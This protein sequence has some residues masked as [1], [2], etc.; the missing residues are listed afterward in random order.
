M[1]VKNEHPQTIAVVLSNLRQLQQAG[2]VSMNREG[3]DEYVV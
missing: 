2:T 3:G 1:F